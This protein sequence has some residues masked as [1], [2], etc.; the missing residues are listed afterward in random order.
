MRS[1]ECY[2]V[3]FGTLEC[4]VVYCIHIRDMIF[5]GVIFCVVVLLLYGGNLFI[6]TIYRYES[7]S[8]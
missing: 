5:C 4:L 6:Y 8:C 3:D 7:Y 1:F 2:T